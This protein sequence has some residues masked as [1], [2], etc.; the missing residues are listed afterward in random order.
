MNKGQ[1]ARLNALLRIQVY[2][3]ANA[4]ALGSVS[5]STSRSDLDSAVTGLKQY[6]AQQSQAE[7]QAV[8]AKQVKDAAREDLRLYHM[9]PIT[10]IAKKKL[11][12][13][14]GIQELALPH[15]NVSDN[16]LIAAGTAMAAQAAQYTQVFLDQQLPADFIAQL[17]AAVKAVEDAVTA[18]STNSLAV[19]DATKSV[20]AQ[21]AITSTDV[22]ILNGLVT[23]QLKGQTGLLG[24]WKNAKR[25][26][27]VAVANPATP[28]PVP[29]TPAP[30][31]ATPA[32][33]AAQEAPHA[34][35]A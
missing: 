4:G 24:A 7:N 26:H 13:T 15:K 18:Q 20:K 10:A 28:A 1:Q 16:D 34:A 11:T 9:Q 17:Q 14:P 21:L 25:V 32:A 12:N 33:P 19:N 23:K 8:S 35:A 29:A 31:P 6:A 30:V 5:K 27:V 3:D 2:L 22:K